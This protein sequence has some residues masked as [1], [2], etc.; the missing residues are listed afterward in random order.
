MDPLVEVHLLDFEGDLYGQ[1]MELEFVERLRP[2][3]RFESLDALQSAITED[4][5]RARAIHAG[6]RDRS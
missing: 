2:E 5:E 3:R 4:V 1:R 6:R